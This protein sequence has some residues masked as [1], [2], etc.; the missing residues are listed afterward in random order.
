MSSGEKCSSWLS[1]GNDRDTLSGDEFEHNGSP[2]RLYIASDG[3]GVNSACERLD[4]HRESNSGKIILL[5][6]WCVK[7]FS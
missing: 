1:E 5:D 2:E 7:N 3:K 4:R 6:L